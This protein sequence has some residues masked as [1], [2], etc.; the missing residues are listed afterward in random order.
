M[1]SFYAIA[2]AGLAISSGAAA[3]DV[4]MGATIIGAADGTVIEGGVIVVEGDRITCVGKQGECKFSGRAVVHDLAGKFITPGLIDSHVHFDQTGWI[5][6]RP[7]A[8]EDRSVYPYEA[9]IAALRADPGRWHRAYLCSG[10][11]AVFDVGGAPWTVTGPQSADSERPDRAHVRAAGPLITFADVPSL[12]SIPGEP[13]FFPMGTDEEALA[14]V[15][16]LKSL[17]SSAV[18]VWFLDPPPDRRAELVARLNLIGR[19]AREAGLPLIVHATELRNAK[20]ALEAGASMLVHSVEDEPVDGEFLALLK[21]NDAIYAPTLVVG[22]QW[23]RSIASVALEEAVSIDDP[24][25]CVDTAILERIA[26]PELLTPALERRWG[27]KKLPIVERF[28]STGREAMVMAQ[29]L[30]AVRDAGGRIVLG[31]DAG[32]SLTVHGP[33]INWEMEAMQAAGLSPEEVIH[34]ATIE[35]ARTMGLDNEIGTLEAGKIADLIV[36]DEDPR[37]GVAAFRSLSAV[38]RAGKLKPQRELQVR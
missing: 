11:T 10:V 5:D 22:R 26:R 24:N 37:Q 9:T 31:T 14:S 20:A 7:D 4:L 38:M 15:A 29:N 8:I 32:N 18:K 30:R 1:K 19:A 12:Q 23:S 6:G 28:E 16:Q 33:S 25:R 13:T 27:S 2:A 3:A 17:G 35:G 36:L 34:A 21:N